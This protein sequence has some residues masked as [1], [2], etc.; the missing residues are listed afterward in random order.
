[1]YIVHDVVW[2]MSGKPL[3]QLTLHTH[4]AFQLTLED[5]HL[6]PIRNKISHD[7]GKPDVDQLVQHIYITFSLLS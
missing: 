7:M 3:I 5:P 1:M 4:A 2:S 6:F